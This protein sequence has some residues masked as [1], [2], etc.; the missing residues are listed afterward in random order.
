MGKKVHLGTQMMLEMVHWPR[1]APDL[2]YIVFLHARRGKERG[3]KANGRSLKRKAWKGTESYKMYRVGCLSHSGKP[4]FSYPVPA[5][6]WG[7]RA[8][9]CH[10][11]PAAPDE[12]CPAKAS[13]LAPCISIGSAGNSSKVTG[14]ATGKLL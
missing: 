12:R 7:M 6:L 13:A 3:H 11:L 2:C 1:R 5:G 10:C 4:L 9:P 14:S 8:P